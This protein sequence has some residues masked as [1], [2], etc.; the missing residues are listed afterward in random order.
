MKIES[1]ALKCVPLK[2]PGENSG[3][4]TSFQ[5]KAEGIIK[6]VILPEAFCLPGILLFSK[7][8]IKKAECGHSYKFK[9]VIS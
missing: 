4:Q 5:R 2:M 9:E 6:H 1:C 7:F 8:R 3:Q